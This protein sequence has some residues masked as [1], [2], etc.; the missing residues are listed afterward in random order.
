VIEK[1]SHTNGRG[2]STSRKHMTIR[3]NVHD[4]CF[5]WNYCV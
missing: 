3:N 2:F 1:S 4:C 5:D